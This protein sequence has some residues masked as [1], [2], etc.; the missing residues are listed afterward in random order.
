MLKSRSVL[1]RHLSSK[2][3]KHSIDFDDI[4]PIK[5]G[6]LKGTFLNQASNKQS[7]QGFYDISGQQ[8][9]A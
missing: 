5:Q 2:Q 7:R 3:D 6:G 1:S 4:V 8:T 9:P